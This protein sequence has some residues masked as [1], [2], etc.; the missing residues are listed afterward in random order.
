MT[1]RAPQASFP[2]ALAQAVAERV[3]QDAA[4]LAAANVAASALPPFAADLGLGL[5]WLAA[6]PLSPTPPSMA[7]ALSRYRAMSPQPVAETPK[8][9]ARSFKA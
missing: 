9:D 4:P 8:A 2:E 7:L 3:R 6:G 1:A 5:P